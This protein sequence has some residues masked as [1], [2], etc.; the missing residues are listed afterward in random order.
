M[1]TTKGII[2][3]ATAAALFAAGCARHCETPA[4]VYHDRMS[5][6]GGMSCKGKMSKYRH[7]NMSSRGDS[8]QQTTAGVDNQQDN[9]QESVQQ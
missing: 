7:R 6:K 3:A 5:C 8:Q 1:K 4:P 9:Q 2:I